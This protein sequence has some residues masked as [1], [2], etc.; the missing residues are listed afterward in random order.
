MTA[1]ATAGDRTRVKICGL[2]NESDRDAAV[3]AGADALGFITDVPVDTP[4]EVSP[5]QATSLVSGAPPLVST[6]LVTMPESVADAVTLQERVGADAIQVHGG[7]SPEELEQLGQRV[8]AVVIGAVDVDDAD[9]FAA[10]SDAL[11]V[12]STDEQGAG[13]T[14]E[15]HD[16]ERTRRLVECVE[17]PVVLAGGLTP[18][19][20]ASA[21][22]AVEPFAVDTATGVERE[23]G[24]KDHDAVAAFVRRA[25]PQEVSA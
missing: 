16:W 7:L 3:R 10:A 20:V 18:D 8:D 17:T 6:A 14:G 19:N 1:G 22:E 5:E 13:G 23:G 12:D 25:G 11:L 21:I 2:T 15:T 9:A 24:R 4:R